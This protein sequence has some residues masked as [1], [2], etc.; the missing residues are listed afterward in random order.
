MSLFGC[1]FYCFPSVQYTLPVDYII[2][3]ELRSVRVLLLQEVH[4]SVYG[5]LLGGNTPIAK[6]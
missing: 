2:Y 6:P 1:F 3:T 5:Q 4:C